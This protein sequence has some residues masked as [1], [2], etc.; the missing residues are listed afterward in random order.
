MKDKEGEKILKFQPSASFKKSRSLKV[1]LLFSFK[2]IFYVEFFF[3]KFVVFSLW[4]DI[5]IF[6]IKEKE[7]FF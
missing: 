5:L 1:C 4:I 6:M 2:I 3:N 7:F